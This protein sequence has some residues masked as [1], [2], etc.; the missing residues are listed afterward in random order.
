MIRRPPRSTR[1]DTHFP[2]A[3]L[4]RSENLGDQEDPED[5]RG[6]VDVEVGQ[7]RVDTEHEDGEPDPVDVGSHVRGDERACEEREDADQGGLEDDVRQRVSAP[8]AI[9]TTRPSPERKST[10]LKS[11]H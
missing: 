7:Q 1:T 8:A 4:F 5:L 10:S 9:P 3:T 6:D 2:Y 11:S